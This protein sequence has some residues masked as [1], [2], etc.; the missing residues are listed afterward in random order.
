MSSVNP[1]VTYNRDELEMTLEIVGKGH[2]VEI[3]S[4]KHIKKGET[5]L[6]KG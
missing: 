1:E 6:K 4:N 3:E 5:V 2:S